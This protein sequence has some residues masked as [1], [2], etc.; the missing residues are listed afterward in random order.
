MKV[1]IKLMIGIDLLQLWSKDT[2]H[3]QVPRV[4]ELV[5]VDCPTQPEYTNRWME[6]KDVRRLM[7]EDHAMVLVQPATD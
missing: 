5:M 2:T 7:D 1:T 4:G 3:M 6:V